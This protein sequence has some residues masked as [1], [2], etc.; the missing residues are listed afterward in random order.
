MP[1]PKPQD[2]RAFTSAERMA[3][4]S[5]RLAERV[6]GT[7]Q[8]VAERIARYSARLAE[9]VAG[10]SQVDDLA[11]AELPRGFGRD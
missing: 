11:A 2:E 4:Y 5:A 6:A 1:L 10:T 8:P 3:R 7:P 9:R